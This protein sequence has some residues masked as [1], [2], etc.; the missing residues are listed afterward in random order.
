MTSV[1]VGGVAHLRV[2]CGLLLLRKFLHLSHFAD[3]LF[4]PFKLLHWRL[5]MFGTKQHP[6]NA[7]ATPSGGEEE[8][9]TASFNTSTQSQATASPG[10]LVYSCKT[11]K[12]RHESHHNKQN[13]SK[14]DATNR[15][16]N[17]SA[18]HSHDDVAN[19][20]NS[21]DDVAN[22][23]HAHLP[24]QISFKPRR[25]EAEENATV[26]SSLPGKPAC[27]CVAVRSLCRPSLSFQL[28]PFY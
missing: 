3:Y 28:S 14:S 9:T 24:L 2:S 27:R 7:S 17:K 11:D 21:R 23:A 20:S 19:S 8:E 6:Y 13:R 26:T 25:F 5:V 16:H 4:S 12:H 10:V 1:G 15:H 22:T 18:P